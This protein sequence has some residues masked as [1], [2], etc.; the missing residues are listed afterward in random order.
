MIRPRA[1]DPR[2]DTAERPSVRRNPLHRKGRLCEIN[3]KFTVVPRS[4]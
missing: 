4:D 2:M 1:V 3:E